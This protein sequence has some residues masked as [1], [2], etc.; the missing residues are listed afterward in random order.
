M[1]N[2]NKLEI[3]GNLRRVIEQTRRDPKQV[4][5]IEE[6][7]G[8]FK[9][10]LCTVSIALVPVYYS[11]RRKDIIIRGFVKSDLRAD[12]AFAGRRVREAKPLI[13]ELTK[14]KTAAFKAA[15]QRQL[16]VPELDTLRLHADVDG[17]WRRR[18]L[19]DE[20]G[21]E[22]RVYQLNAACCSVTLPNGLKLTVGMAPE[23]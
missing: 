15:V 19:E 20:D 22:K 12:V 14:M 8:L 1:G 4:S 16:P 13:E 3:I 21:W 2:L 6:D 9:T 11:N 10:D 7:A 5:P 23:R 18:F 17:T